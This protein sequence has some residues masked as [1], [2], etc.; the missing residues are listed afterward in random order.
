MF[1]E[2][3]GVSP[4]IADGVFIAHGAV[5][6]GRVTVRE[7][8]SIWFNVVMRADRDVITIGRFTN[9]QDNCTV[10]LDPGKPA[11]VGDYVTVGHGAIVHGCVI[12]DNCLIGMNATV[13][14]GATIGRNS[15]VGANALVPENAVIPPGSLVLG[16]PGK[17]VRTLKPEDHDRIRLSAINYHEL[18]R[19]YMR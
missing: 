4:T 1:V 8:A 12:E 9:I 5:L 3:E 11:I 16:V 14:S 6:I 7:S 2:Y 13:L 17:V 15:I 10:H 19:K 18:S